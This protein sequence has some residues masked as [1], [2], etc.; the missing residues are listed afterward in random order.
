MHA[1]HVEQDQLETVQALA[2]EKA[3]G[4]ALALVYEKVLE[5]ALALAHKKAL[6]KVQALASEKGPEK[7]Q[8]LAHEKGPEKVLVLVH[9]KGPEKVQALAY[10]KAAEVV[11][12]MEQLRLEQGRLWAEE[13]VCL[14]RQ[15]RWWRHQPLIHPPPEA[16]TLHQHAVHVHGTLLGLQLKWVSLD[17]E[18]KKKKTHNSTFVRSCRRLGRYTS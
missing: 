9:E 7:V 11:H 3:L 10:E 4:M 13:M 14:A 6:E 15:C 8:A 18:Q 5:T 2:H 17:L 12:E 16:K 1:T